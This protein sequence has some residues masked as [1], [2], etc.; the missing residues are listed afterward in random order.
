MERTLEFTKLL[1]TE[2]LFLQV[3]S[4]SAR[5]NTVT[6]APV[7]FDRAVKFQF[8]S[9]DIEFDALNVNGIA[10]TCVAVP[11][12]PATSLISACGD[13]VTGTGILHGHIFSSNNSC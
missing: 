7:S 2:V 13:F 12:P 6:V 5:L 10:S 4:I 11:P 9:G 3:H 8:S 1:Q